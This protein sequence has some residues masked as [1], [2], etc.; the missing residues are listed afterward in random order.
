MPEMIDFVAIDH[1]VIRVK[2]L[3]S[4]L[5]FY[6]GVLGMDVERRLDIGLVQLR[7]GACLIDLVPVDGDIGRSG[8]GAPDPDH[9]NMDH[10]C[11][12]VGDWDEEEI[13]AWLAAKGV[14]AGPAERRYGAGGFGPSI[15]LRDPEG[16]TVELK[17]PADANQSER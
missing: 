13:L 7:A 14:K 11:L 6:E 1:V 12:T 8:G 10:F 4:M 15:Y 2:N 9:R 5:G 3:D 16:N 17:G